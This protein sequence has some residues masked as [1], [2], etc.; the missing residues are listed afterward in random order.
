MLGPAC[1]DLEQLWGRL[2]TPLLTLWWDWGCWWLVHRKWTMSLSPTL[3]FT[4]QCHLLFR[5]EET[6]EGQEETQ[7]YRAT[8]SHRQELPVLRA[9]QGHGGR[10]LSAGGPRPSP[11]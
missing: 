11:R 10:A 5:P 1:L 9:P 3:P 6:E 7:P 4:S 2:H 8:C